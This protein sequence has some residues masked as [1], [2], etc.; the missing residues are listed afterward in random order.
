[1]M[2]VQTIF[3]A[4]D[5]PANLGRVIGVSTE[6]ASTMR[7]RQSIPVRYWP[8]IVAGSKETGVSL[9]PADLMEAHAPPRAP[10]MDVD[11]GAAA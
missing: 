3:D 5:G 7:R 6:H 10:S 2:T 9:S 1:M 11:E 8:A 4:F